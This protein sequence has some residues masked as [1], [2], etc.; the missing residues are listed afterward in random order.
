M[1]PKEHKQKAAT[2]P[3]RKEK[4]KEKGNERSSRRASVS[5]SKTTPLRV[6]KKKVDRD[7][8][9]GR[10]APKNL[11]RQS[12]VSTGSLAL[13]A[14]VRSEWDHSEREHADHRKDPSTLK[15]DRACSSCPSPVSVAHCRA[16]GKKGRP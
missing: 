14:Q 2:Q 7:V 3:A 6:E 12:E 15:K 10:G 16:S 1:C 9:A 8:C 5:R 13:T 11:R 4:E